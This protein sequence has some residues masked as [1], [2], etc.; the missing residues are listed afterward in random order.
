MAYELIQDF[1]YTNSQKQISILK[2]G[3]RFDSLVDDFY[4]FK[5]G[6]VTYRLDK[7]TVE[8]NP[9]YFKRVDL[10]TLLADLI[11]KNK[12]ATSPRLAKMIKDFFETHY[13]NNAEIVNNELLMVMLEAC[14]I[15]FFEK[16]DSAYLKPFKTLGYKC[17]DNGVFK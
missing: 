1:H 3:T 8:G 10:E 12:K 2:K 7:E 17:D 9:D 14:R 6:K 4:L 11:K 13:L 5:I 16:N 15:Q